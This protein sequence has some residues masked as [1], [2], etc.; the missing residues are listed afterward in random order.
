MV[1]VY[2]CEKVN[3]LYVSN[4][5]VCY[6]INIKIIMLYNVDYLGFFVFFIKIK[7]CWVLLFIFFLFFILFYYLVFKMFVVDL[8]Y[9][10]EDE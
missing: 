4:S 2:F 7:K 8:G 1:G 10:L 5:V 9:F 3:F 6:V